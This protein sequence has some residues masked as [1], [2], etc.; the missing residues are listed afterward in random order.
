MI[1]D[2]LVTT[3]T[4]SARVGQILFSSGV[5]PLERREFRQAQHARCPRFTSTRQSTHL[6]GCNT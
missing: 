5:M 2:S 3:S 4:H 6:L 1:A